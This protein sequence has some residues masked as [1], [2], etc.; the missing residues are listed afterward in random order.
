MTKLYTDFEGNPA[1]KTRN[2]PITIASSDEYS[3]FLGVLIKSIIEN[4]SKEW[5]Y[6]IVILSKGIRSFNRILL[7]R[8]IENHSNF[9]IRY[10]DITDYLT[11]YEFHTD[12]HITIM[13]YSRL[14]MIDIFKDY[15]KV[16]YLDCDVILNDDIQK[17][18]SI[19]LGNNFVAAARDTV[20]AGIVNL[21]KDAK[22]LIDEDIRREQL[23]YNTNVLG[24]KDP[25]NYFN[26]G[27]IVVNLKEIKKYYKGEDLLKIAA[28]KNWKWFD[29]DVLNKICYGKTVILPQTWNVMSHDW[30]IEGIKTENLAPDYIRKEY[31]EARAKPQAI[32]YCGHCIPCFAPC[33]DNA[34]KFWYYAKQTEFYERILFTMMSTA[35][36]NI[37]YS[38]E[39]RLSLA[40]RIADKLL[41]KGS[42]R[43]NLLKKIMPRG[44]WLFEFLKKMYHKCTI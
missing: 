10:F 32:H 19:D 31:N 29:Q 6:D 27:I 8:E 24:V 44:S 5:N 13:T 1:F 28:A 37:L 33:V 41:P 30:N 39:R 16:V 2:I 14:A 42:R 21:D 25:T 3:Q 26:A 12:Y 38:G 17:L 18:F 22:G 9:S 35:T 43:R 34:E 11:K 40:R 7:N 36:Y 20:I 4:S 15:D 23:S